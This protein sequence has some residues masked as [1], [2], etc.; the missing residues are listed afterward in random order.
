MLHMNRCSGC[1]F[2]IPASAECPAG[3]CNCCG[4]MFRLTPAIRSWIDLRGC[5]SFRQKPIID[6][7][8]SR[9]AKMLDKY[10]DAIAGTPRHYHVVSPL[11]VVQ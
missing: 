8:T 5:C 10:M 1:Q 2:L 9:A 4:L 11:P 6:A 7:E 3:G